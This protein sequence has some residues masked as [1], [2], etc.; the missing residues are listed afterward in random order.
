MSTVTVHD[1][2]TNLSKYIAAAKK[3]KKI[4][5]GR[6]GRPEVMLVKISPKNFDA[7]QNRDFS[8]ARGKIVVSKESFS[9]ETDELVSKLLLNTE[10]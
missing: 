1:A 9:R 8:P 6:F 2:K 10:Q 7:P 5:I 4:F 3:G